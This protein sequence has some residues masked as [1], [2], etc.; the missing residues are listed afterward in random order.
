[1]KTFPIKAVVEWIKII[2]QTH[3][4]FVIDI[5][6]HFSKLDI[7]NRVISMTK[8]GYIFQNTVKMNNPTRPVKLTYY[9]KTI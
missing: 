5:T 4:L 3:V 2:Y 1:M 9:V 7:K 8:D 6:R